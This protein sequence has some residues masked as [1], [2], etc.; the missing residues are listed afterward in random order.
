MRQFQ[1]DNEEGHKMRSEGTAKST[2]ADLPT[3]R[4]HQRLEDTNPIW[5]IGL[6]L[7]I[8]VLHVFDCPLNFR[9]WVELRERLGLRASPKEPIN[10]GTCRGICCHGN[11]FAPLVLD[12][13]S[14]SG[15]D[16][17]V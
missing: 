5:S 17:I 2:Y 1:L 15:N 13:R 10:A 7:P 14:Q 12:V 11:V 3:S 9:I 6:R 8:A 4:V 16:K